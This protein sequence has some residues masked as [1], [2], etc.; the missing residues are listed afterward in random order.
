[1]ESLKAVI[2]MENEEKIVVELY[3]KYAPLTVKNFIDLCRKNFYSG[4]TFHRIVKGFVIQ[5]GCPNGDGTGG[6]GYEIK[7]EFSTNGINNTL[8]HTKGVISMARSSDPDSAGSQ[9]FIMLDDHSHLDGNYAAFGKV[10]H[11][12]E[13]VD[14]IGKSK[15]DFRDKPLVPVVIKSI[16]IENETL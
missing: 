6:P 10:I 4:L 7:G 13:V 8:K 5:G 3:E 16:S 1:M 9:F 15:V 11:G 2:T 14:K 12:M